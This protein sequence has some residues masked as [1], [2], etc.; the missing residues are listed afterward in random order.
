MSERGSEENCQNRF[1]GDNLTDSLPHQK[2]RSNGNGSENLCTFS[3]KTKDV[4][5]I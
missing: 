1:V 3:F 5:N 4:K 2:A